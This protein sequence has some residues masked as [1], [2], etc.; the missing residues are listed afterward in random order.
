MRRVSPLGVLLGLAGWA[1]CEMPEF[2]HIARVDLGAI[3]K[4]G[5]LVGEEAADVA[6]DGTNIYIAGFSLSTP[7]VPTGI[8]KVVSPLSFPSTST[9]YTIATQ[10]GGGRDTKL[11]YAA[12]SLYLGTGLGWIGDAA[13]GIRKVSLSGVADPAFAGTGVLVPTAV[14]GLTNQRTETLAIDPVGNA[15]AVLNRNQQPV[16]RRDLSSGAAL[17]SAAF[18]SAPASTGWRDLCFDASGNAYFRDANDVWKADRMDATHL[19]TRN[20]FFNLGAIDRAQCNVLWIAGGTGYEP[21]VLF[22]SRVNDQYSFVFYVNEGAGPTDPVTELPT[23][24]LDGSEPIAGVPQAP[25]D[26]SLLNFATGMLGGRR[27]LFVVQGGANDKLSIY[28]IVESNATSTVRG[29]LDLGGFDPARIGGKRFVAEIRRAGVAVDSQ[30]FTLGQDFRY[31]FETPI[32][33]VVDIAIQGRPW[34]R[35]VAQNVTLSQLP[36]EVPM[37]VLTNGDIDGDNSVNIFDYNYMSNAFDLTEFD[38]GWAVP[39][40]EGVRPGDADLD[41]DGAVTI[42]DYNVLST[43]FDVTGDP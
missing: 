38:A 13:T 3:F 29:L 10:Y 32:Q 33:G 11:A 31:E 18:A 28:E 24:R 7:A 2:R 41:G 16:F 5:S 1:S 15:L 42:F 36:A 17:A 40:S 39:D 21:T 22:N 35:R 19:G 14:A 25:F 34:M 8:L 20:L 26:S 23:H 6:T 12:G 30:T 4:I 27:C 37:L 9:L 43:N